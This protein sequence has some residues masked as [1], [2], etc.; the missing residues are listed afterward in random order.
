VTQG[1]GPPNN[2]MKRTRSSIDAWMASRGRAAYAERWKET[3]ERRRA[4]KGWA[5]SERPVAG[6]AAVAQV[7]QVRVVAGGRLTH[8]VVRGWRAE[9]TELF[10]LLGPFG[11]AAVGPMSQS[12]VGR[13]SQIGQ[14]A[15]SEVCGLGP[16]ASGVEGEV[17]SN[18]RVKRTRESCSAW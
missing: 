17:P 16:G 11:V 4:M 13:P 6:V 14:G 15:S 2:R 7:D 12:L 18:S 9:A 1:T 3:T 10:G 8:R 5:P